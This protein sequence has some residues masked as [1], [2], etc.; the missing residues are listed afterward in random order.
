M[1]NDRLLS[2]PRRLEIRL[3]IAAPL[4]KLVVLRLELGAQRMEPQMG[5]DTCRDAPSASL[6]Q[7]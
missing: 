5:L 7:S 3:L 2:E 1:R 4:F 6:I